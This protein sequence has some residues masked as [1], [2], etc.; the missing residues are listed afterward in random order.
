[1]AKI[2]KVGHAFGLSLGYDA[3]SSHA[4]EFQTGVLNGVDWAT[5][6]TVREEGADRVRR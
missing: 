5:A 6:P 1:M 3:Q 2:K 4:S